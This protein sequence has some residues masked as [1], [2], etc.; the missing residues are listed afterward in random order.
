MTGC[1][2]RASSSRFLGRYLGCLRPNQEGRQG[3]RV[4]T[5]SCCG[6]S[7]VVHYRKRR[8]VWPRTGKPSNSNI[9]LMNQPN[10]HHCQTSSCSMESVSVLGY[11]R[12]TSY[13]P[14]LIKGFG[15]IHCRIVDTARVMAK[16]GLTTGD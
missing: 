2:L 7:K 9:T 15:D 11:F 16:S 3:W 12:R 6:C 8:P 5:E 4:G 1:L 10:P 14:W 13:N